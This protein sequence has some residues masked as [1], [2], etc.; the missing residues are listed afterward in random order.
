MDPSGPGEPSTALGDGLDAA[1]GS[2]LAL[3]VAS[4]EVETASQKIQVDMLRDELEASRAAVAKLTAV[5]DASYRAM[6]VLHDRMDALAAEVLV[7][8]ADRWSGTGGSPRAIGSEPTAASDH[9]V[10]DFGS[11]VHLRR[12]SYSLF[13]FLLIFFFF[14]FFFFFWCVDPHVVMIVTPG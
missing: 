12:S 14:F 9:A 4:L 2:S 5:A 10:A 8:R 3:R 13:S 1:N 11:E 6:G 7:L